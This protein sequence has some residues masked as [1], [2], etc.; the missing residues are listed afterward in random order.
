[1]KP[2]MAHNLLQSIELVANV[3]DLLADRCVADIEANRETCEENAERSLSIVTAL[4]PHIGYDDAAEI[5]KQAMKEGRTIREVARDH[6][7][8]D[9]ELDD[10]LDVRRMTERGI[11]D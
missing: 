10:Y 7:L 4:A 9:D 1:M 2:V 5:A 11:L 6:G 8:S 3:S